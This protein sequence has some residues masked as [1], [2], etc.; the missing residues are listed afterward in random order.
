M[1][2]KLKGTYTD[3]IL[4]TDNAEYSCIEQIKGMINSPAFT[5]PVRIM[6]DTHAGKGSVVGFTMPVGDKLVPNTIGVDI[7]CLDKDTEYLTPNGWKKIK[8]FVDGDYVLQYNKDTQKT[9]F[10]RPINYIVKPCDEFFHYKNSKGMDQMLSE[11]HKMLVFTGYKGR[12]YKSITLS[13]IELN[14]K[15]L[16]KGYYG[17]KAA[18]ETGESGVPISDDMI[19]L[20]IAISADGCIR[21][22]NEGLNHIE[23][24]LS[25]ERKIK[26]MRKILKDSVIKYKETKNKNSTYFY[27]KVPEIIDKELYYYYAAN[28]KQ[29]KI[30]IDECLK[31]DGHEG[32]RSYFSSTNKNNADVIQY[33]FSACGI[34][35]G[36]SVV[37]SDKW[38]DCYVVTPTKNEVVSYSQPTKVKSEDGKKYC[39]TVPT[40]YFV[41]RRNGKIFVTGNCG[42]Y[43]YKIDNVDSSSINF[44][45]IDNKIRSVVPLGFNRRTA[46]RETYEE[47]CQLIPGLSSLVEKLKVNNEKVV[48]QLGSLGGGNHFIEFAKSKN[49][50][51]LWLLIHTGS[52]NI[53]KMTCE[54]HQNKAIK[55]IDESRNKIIKNVLDNTPDNEK[56]DAMNAVKT[57]SRMFNVSNEQAWLVDEDKEE[58]LQDMQV[59]QKFAHL[60]KHFIR[61][62]ICKECGFIISESIESV[63]NYIDFSDMVIRK[64]AIKADKDELVVI[65]FNMRDGSILAR[66]KGNKD[67]NNSAPH[68]AGRIMSRSFAKKNVNLEEFENTMKDVWSTSV[69]IHTLDESPFAYKPKEEI[70]VAITDTVEVYD[71]LIP[72]YNLKDS[73]K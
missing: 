68:G 39:F 71:Y 18:F 62:A 16:N 13:P 60:N 46:Y 65:P 28:K 27:F 66:G 72:I 3:A 19:R 59:A 57:G 2:V 52:R 56:Q 42:I 31:W 63:H 35:A 14:K 49:D 24:H 25:K 22:T 55:Y 33:A 20:D 32:Y 26:R 69:N 51:S 23:M 15:S 50:N 17:F 8:E 47:I 21:R 7:G 29:L 70:E 73:K 38:S 12:G 48:P 10:V 9:N 36:I 1:T 58:Y 4:Y 11:E 53:G 64:G 5:E 6:P 40:G 34:R 54:Y 41:A 30:V 61:D 37:R 44:E 67:W 43:A 45:D